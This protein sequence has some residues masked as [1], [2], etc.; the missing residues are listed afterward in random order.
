[1]TNAVASD[2]GPTRRMQRCLVAAAVVIVVVAVSSSSS[3]TTNSTA[4]SVEYF[5][6]GAVNTISCNVS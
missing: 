6:T 1:M 2:I 3:S 4:A 5:C